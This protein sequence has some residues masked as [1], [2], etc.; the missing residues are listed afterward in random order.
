ME[1]KVY[2][3]KVGKW[4]VLSSKIDNDLSFSLRLVQIQCN[5]TEFS[6]DNRSFERV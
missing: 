6:R 4:Q 5:F 2:L 1:L 3:Y